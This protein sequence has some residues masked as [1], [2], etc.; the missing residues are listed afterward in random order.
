MSRYPL[1]YLLIGVLVGLIAATAFVMLTLGGFHMGEYDLGSLVLFMSV[2]GLTTV[3]IAYFIYQRGLMYWFPSLRSAL[4]ISIVIAVLLVLP[5]VWVTAQLMFINETDFYLTTGLL[6]FAGVIALSFGL[7]VASVIINRIRDLSRAAESLA[8][9]K[10]ETRLEVHGKDELTQFA[11]TFNW[12]AER[13]QQIDE[14]KRMVEKTRR[15]LIA[16]VSHD[17]RTPLTSIR[18]MLEAINDE[19]VTDPQI[20]TRYIHNSLAEIENLNHLINDLF[21]L[22]QL[23]AG[24]LD[25]Q[26][27]QASL[28]DLLSDVISR[29]NAQAQKR[30]IHLDCEIETEIDPVYM[31]PD[32][33]QRVLYNLLDNAIRYT[34]MEGRVTLRARRE[35]GQVQVEVHNTGSYIE[36]EHLPRVFDSFYRIESSRA[37]GEDGHRGTGLGLAIARGLIEAHRGN[38]RI[39]SDLQRGTMFTF[40]IPLAP[41]V[42]RE[43]SS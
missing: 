14:Q 21:E 1:V 36:P 43:R 2:S 27:V 8:Q 3:L 33:I 32:K 22:A 20:V 17:L 34:P 10:L 26:F 15:D 40:S 23:D 16:G 35:G 19:I 29:M 41:A 11:Q 28:K 18:A 30:H 5:N 42:P 24:H 31:A 25:A 9:G 6:I 12:M 38:I 13:L 7:Y 4:L 39:D 37:Q